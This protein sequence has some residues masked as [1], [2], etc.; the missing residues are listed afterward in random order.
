[1]LLKPPVPA[2]AGD[3][4]ALTVWVHPLG[5]QRTQDRFDD[6]CKHVSSASSLRA[7][8]PMMLAAEEKKSMQPY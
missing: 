2:A 5:P 1:M 3:V 6:T 7:G 8:R 4:T